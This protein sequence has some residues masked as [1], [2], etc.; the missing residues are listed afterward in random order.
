VLSWSDGMALR[1]PACREIVRVALIDMV[2]RRL[3][4]F[5]ILSGLNP[6]AN[7]RWTLQGLLK[8]RATVVGDAM[9]KGISGGERK[10]LCVAMDLLTN[11]QLLFL[12]EPTSGPLCP[13]RHGSGLAWPLVRPKVTTLTPNH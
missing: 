3:H 13:T 8:C 7:A 2:R 10:R 12:D 6:R 1:P 11:P 9:R 5:I 4:T